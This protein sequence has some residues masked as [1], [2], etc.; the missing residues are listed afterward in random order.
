MKTNSGRSS[1]SFALIA[2]LILLLLVGCNKNSTSPSTGI[3]NTPVAVNVANSFTYTL[4]ASGYSATTGYD[5]SFNTDSLVCTLVASNYSSGNATVTIASPP[6]GIAI[7]DSV[8][9]NTVNVTVQSGTGIPK[10]CSLV[11][12]N[13]TGKFSLVLAKYQTGH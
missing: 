11:F 6:G 9:S 3:N 7:H 1:W 5:L 2:I 8:F 10:Q 12:Q 4:D 13:F